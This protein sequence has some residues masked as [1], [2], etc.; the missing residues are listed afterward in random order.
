MKLSDL[1]S[2]ADY[3]ELRGVCVRTIQRE[4]AL[5]SGPPYIKL[6]RRIFYKLSSIDQWLDDQ[7]RVQPR[8]KGGAS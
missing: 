4:R 5:R 7:E 1:I 6:G 3:A 8:A 2:E